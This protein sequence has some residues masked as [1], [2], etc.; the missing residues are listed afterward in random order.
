MNGKAAFVYSDALSGHVLRADHPL[1]AV[2]LRYTYDLLRSYGAFEEDGALLLEPRHAT[3]EEL[4]TLHTREYIE[5]VKRFGRG[6]MST[7]P[8]RFN[9]SVGGDNPIYDGMYGASTLSTGA[10]MG[11]ACSTTRPSPSTT[12]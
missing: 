11:S 1:R 2:R 8:S 7:D 4:A 5:A 12:C 6:D 10:S 3:D 9:F